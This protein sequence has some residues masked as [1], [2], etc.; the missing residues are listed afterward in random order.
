[1]LWPGYSSLVLLQKSWI[2]INLGASWS[3]LAA[4]QQPWVEKL[5]YL[6]K[7]PGS[8]DIQCSNKANYL[9]SFSRSPTRYDSVLNLIY[10]VNK[11]WSL[12]LSAL[13]SWKEQN[14]KKNVVQW[15]M[16]VINSLQ[17][18]ASCPSD[19]SVIIL[20]KMLH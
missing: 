17:V 16:I 14:K 8:W 19:F 11:K 20:D 6:V 3:N 9:T 7:C 2:V 4:N 10:T 12:F 5:F 13:P 1:M 18:V 15:L